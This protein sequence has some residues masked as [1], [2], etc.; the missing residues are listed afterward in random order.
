MDAKE[1]KP[2]VIRPAGHYRHELKYNITYWQYLQLRSR[3]RQVM[4]TDPHTEAD[5]TYQIRSILKDNNLCMK[6][7]AGL[8]EAECRMLLAGNLEWM[9]NHPSS[10]VQELYGKMKYQQLRPRVLVS[11]TREPYIYAAGN[12]RI[13]FDWNV[14]TTMYHQKFLEEKVYDVEAVQCPGEMIMEVKYDAFLPRVIQDLIQMDGVRQQSFS[15]YGA[16]RNYG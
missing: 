6:V 15:K 8:K 10:L 11:Y 5:G 1:I 2:G 14:R 7:S 3:F 12:V 4:K 9:R 16:C 13:T